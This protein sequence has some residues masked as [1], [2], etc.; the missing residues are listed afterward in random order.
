MAKAFIYDAVG[1]VDATTVDGT[2][3]GA[4]F[5]PEGTPGDAITDYQLLTDQ[6]I[7]NGT[8][9]G[10]D[11]AL[12]IDFGAS[13]DATKLIV[14]FSAVE[15][16]NVELWVGDH[17]TAM[18]NDQ[19]VI[20]QHTTQI[21][22]GWTIIDLGGTISGR[23]WFIVADGV[24]ENFT[25]I[26]IGDQLDFALNPNLGGSEGKLFGINVMESYGGI[27]YTNRRHAGKTTWN[28]NWSLISSAMRGNLETFRDACE[29]DRLKYLYY[30][31]TSY[32]YCRMDASSLNFT[33]QAYL[34]YSTPFSQREQIS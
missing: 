2:T 24:L 31:E 34:A 14:N 27:E 21:E 23:Y 18:D 15:T 16:D 26:I 30:D 10:D 12:R 7:G 9:F 11:D 22:S 17:A 28:W 25:E 32:F 20:V 8:G 4:A 19:G 29:K 6:S 1:T 13:V 33:E 3:A 5:T